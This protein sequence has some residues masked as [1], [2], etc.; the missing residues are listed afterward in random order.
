MPE[1][2]PPAGARLIPGLEQVCVPRCFLLS[3]RPAHRAI[4]GTAAVIRTAL[5]LRHVDAV[6]LLEND[7]WAT[8]LAGEIEVGG[9]GDELTP[10]GAR[11]AKDIGGEDRRS[12]V[13]QHDA[14]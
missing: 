5:R 3:V 11:P 14:R 8:T 6:A 10:R 1:R 2:F 4:V 12:G 9:R 13:G 7:A